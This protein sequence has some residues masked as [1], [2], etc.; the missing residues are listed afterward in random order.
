M[1]Q[2]VF[3]CNNDTLIYNVPTPVYQPE[4]DFR[5]I[6]SRVYSGGP[7]YIKAQVDDVYVGG[8]NVNLMVAYN[9]GLAVDFGTK[10]LYYYSGCSWSQISSNS[11]EWLTAYNGNLAADFGATYGLYSYDGSAWS[12]ISTSDPGN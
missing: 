1:S 10:G 7:G 12:Q 3:T 8:D 4:N 2:L 11:S 6:R 5:A 9:N